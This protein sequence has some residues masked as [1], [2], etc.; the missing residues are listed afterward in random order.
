MSYEKHDVLMKILRADGQFECWDLAFAD[1]L[2]YGTSDDI[3]KMVEN[4]L[5]N[6]FNNDGIYVA[7]DDDHR[8]TA[9]IKK[10]CCD[11][12]FFEENLLRMK[13]D[14][15][16]KLGKKFMICINCES[17]WV[18]VINGRLVKNGE[19]RYDPDV[20]VYL[21][22]NENAYS[23]DLLKI[24]FHYDIDASPISDMPKDDPPR[25]CNLKSW[26]YGNI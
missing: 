5:P 12:T 20:F 25:G 15:L 2:Y 11:K 17:M 10:A 26:Y 18:D 16:K 9:E 7:Y 4:I 23:A 3:L 14:D 19:L 8:L 24:M 6:D 13:Y 1:K 22:D 21:Y